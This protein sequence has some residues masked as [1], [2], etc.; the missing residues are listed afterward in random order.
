MLHLKLRHQKIAI[1]VT[2]VTMLIFL[3]LAQYAQKIGL[4]LRNP[5][6]VRAFVSNFGYWSPFVFAT[7]QFL[8]TILLWM[9]GTLFHIAGGYLFGPYWGTFYSVIGSSLG[10]IAVFLLAKKYND[11]LLDY[12]IDK[13]DVQ[14][15]KEIVRKKGTAA[16]IIAHSVPMLFPHDVLEIV[17]GASGMKTRDYL[18]ISTLSLIPNIFLWSYFGEK[19]ARGFSPALIFVLILIVLVAIF[20]FMRH[21]IKDYLIKEVRIFRELI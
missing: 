13:R 10:S 17:A 12:F 21:K 5:D 14:H 20:Y 19:L 6:S 7:L 15:I 2:L 3:M 16:I 8:E 4:D 18:V 9:P 1:I 11:R